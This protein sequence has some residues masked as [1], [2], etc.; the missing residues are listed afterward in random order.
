MQIVYS[1]PGIKGDTATG[2]TKKAKLSTGAEVMVPLFIEQGEWIQIDT[3]V[4]QYVGRA[5]K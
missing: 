3:R 4:G 2:A 1:E 5:K